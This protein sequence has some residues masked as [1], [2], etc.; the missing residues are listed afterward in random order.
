MTRSGVIGRAG[1]LPW[2]LSSDLK[3]FKSLTMGHAIIMG[4]KTFESLGRVLPGRT[5]IAVSRR[6][7]FAAPAG[8]VVFPDLESAIAAAASDAE[9]FVIGGG[10]LFGPALEP[11]RRMYVTWVESDVA[12]DVYFPPV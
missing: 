9:P 11:C 10:Q 4:R 1:G 6:R 12:G 2:H 7:D 3:R 8:F 5:T